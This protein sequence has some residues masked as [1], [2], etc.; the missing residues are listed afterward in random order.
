MDDAATKIGKVWLVGAGPGDAG[1][2]TRKGAA[3]LAQAGVPVTQ[4]ACADK[5]GIGYCVFDT[6]AEITDELI[7][8]LRN[9]E[10]VLAIRII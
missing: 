4:S 3:V 1:L 9:T 5:K 6:D 7:E 10:N 8:Q 2:F